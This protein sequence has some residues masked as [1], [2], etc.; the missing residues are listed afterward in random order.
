MASQLM[1]N[2]LNHVIIGSRSTEKGNAALKDLQGRGHPG[3]A[4]MVQLDVDSY[5]SISKAAKTVEEKHGK[6][7]T[8]RFQ[9][10]VVPPHPV[11]PSIH[12]P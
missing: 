1:A 11:R 6:Y 12:P 3:S 5:E 9:F 2:K 10:C 4:E 8:A 7:V